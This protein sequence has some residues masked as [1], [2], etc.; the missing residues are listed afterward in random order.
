MSIINNDFPY[1]VMLPNKVVA[2]KASSTYDLGKFLNQISDDN[3][4]LS[5]VKQIIFDPVF[6]A[7]E[8]SGVE[9]FLNQYEIKFPAKVSTLKDVVSNKH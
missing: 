2:Y 9:P 7:D 1:L 6:D 8:H 3:H 5:E 4:D